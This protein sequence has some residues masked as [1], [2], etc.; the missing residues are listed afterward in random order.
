MHGPKSVATLLMQKQNYICHQEK[1]LMPS[2]LASPNVKYVNLANRKI[3]R[4]LS[5]DVFSILIQPL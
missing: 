3:L 1:L 2:M 5:Q 4:L